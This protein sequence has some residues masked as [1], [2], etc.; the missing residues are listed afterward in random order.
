MDGGGKRERRTSGRGGRA[1]EVGGR[2]VG[3]ARGWS[4]AGRG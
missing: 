1:G 4:R 3:K 2:W